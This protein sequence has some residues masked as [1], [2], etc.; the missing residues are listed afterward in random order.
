M[1]PRRSGFEEFWSPRSRVY[2]A[3][4]DAARIR[5]LIDPFAVFCARRAALALATTEETRHKL[6]GLG[7][8]RVRVASE[9]ALPQTDITRLAALPPPPRGTFRLLSVGR[10]LHWKGFGLVIRAFRKFE[11]SFPGSEYWIVGDGPERE[12][13]TKLA[14]QLGLRLKVKFLGPLP[15][16]AVLEKLATVSCTGAPQPS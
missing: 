8:N 11:R 2:E 10:L 9:A 13:L 7:C 14:G 4:R 15:R 6:S 16:A 12:N 3:L 1:S 5:T